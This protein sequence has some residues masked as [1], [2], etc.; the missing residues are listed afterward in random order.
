MK[1]FYVR[2]NVSGGNFK[3]S[4]KPFILDRLSLYSKK[5]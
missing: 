1:Y 4:L 5:Q 2:W 3:L